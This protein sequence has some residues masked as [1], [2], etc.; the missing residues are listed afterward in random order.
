MKGRRSRR[1]RYIRYAPRIRAAFREIAN[2]CRRWPSP[3]VFW[4]KLPKRPEPNART[5]IGP[6]WGRERQRDA[7]QCMDRWLAQLGLDR[8]GEPLNPESQS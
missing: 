7:L 5:T 3:E 8:F 6:G 2:S 1:R 4:S